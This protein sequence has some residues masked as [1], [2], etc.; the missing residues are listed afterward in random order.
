MKEVVSTVLQRLFQSCPLRTERSYTLSEVSN[1]Y[2][3]ND[4]WIVICDHVY[5]VTPFLDQHP[6]GID[7]MMEHAGRDATVAFYGAG[8]HPSTMELLEAYCIGSLAQHERV[9]LIDSLAPNS[10]RSSIWSTEG[11]VVA[12]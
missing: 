1:H 10:R 2:H 7:I 4:C 8:H 3:R 9:N 11:I 12:D 5:D 6:G